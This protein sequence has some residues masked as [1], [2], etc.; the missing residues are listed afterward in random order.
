MLVDLSSERT[1]QN[2]AAGNEDIASSYQFAISSASTQPTDKGEC[3]HLTSE[4]ITKSS[5]HSQISFSGLK[6]KN[7]GTPA[8]TKKIKFCLGLKHLYLIQTILYFYIN[9][10]FHCT[11]HMIDNHMM[12]HN[13]KSFLLFGRSHVTE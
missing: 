3:A 10:Y 12:I 9:M 8:S 4:Q 11:H 2:S 7:K 5:F 1:S 13:V 6:K